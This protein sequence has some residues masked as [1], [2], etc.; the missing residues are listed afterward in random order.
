MLFRKFVFAIFLSSVVYADEFRFDPPK[1]F[2][3]SPKYIAL[4]HPV[5]TDKLAA[6]AFFDQGLT[7][8]Y[9]FNHEAAYWS[10][11]RASEEDPS[12]PMAYWGQAL[13]LGANI[14]I[15]IVPNRAEVAYQTIQKALQLLD[16]AT[17][18]EKDYINALSE[19]YSKD[20]NADKLQLAVNYN[21]AMHKL[22][23]KYPDDPDA[24][25]LYAESV[26]NLSPWN[27]WSGGA[28]REG[29]EDA[30]KALD[31][32]LLSHPM[33]LGANH[34]YIHIIEASPHP[35]RGLMSAERL[36]TM[37][38]SSGHISHMPAHIFLLVGDYEQA[39]LANERAIA[40]DREY[41]RLYG[42]EGTYP[43]HYLSHN[44]HFL[45]QAYSMQGNYG[46]ARQAA[47]ALDNLY[48]S[49]FSKMPELE[50]YASTLMFTNLRFHK[51]KELLQMPPPAKEAIIT[52][53]LWHFGRSAAFASLGNMQESEKEQK[54]FLENRAKV[55]ASA[56][57]GFNQAVK[58]MELAEFFLEAKMAEA[59][60]QNSQAIDWYGKAIGAQDALNYDEPPNWLFSVRDSL[61][62]ILLKEKRY[63][64][65]EKVFR[66]DLKHHPRN[67]RSLFGL[68]TSLKEQ[69]KMT[70]YYF[71]EDLFQNAWR[72]S[73]TELTIYNL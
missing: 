52:N 69:N 39:A 18:N 51:W 27:Q 34:Y 48:L 13:V 26:L 19:R 14:N 50:Q 47:N 37:L 73:D 72:F 9:A 4:H 40:A 62:A 59:K 71:V 54:L 35:E 46:S 1:N 3:L 49:H 57:Y 29:T 41:I 67:G 61:G 58:V 2:T 16:K 63:E 45:S 64:E 44:Y 28:P 30:I 42:L 68:K 17:E 23:D 12:M 6:Q 55:S 15:D 38:P 56:K 20:Q 31:R 53:A 25:V 60:G 24:T 11:I 22:M 33:H 32:V 21:Q 66:E 36:K 8:L 5:E 10:F 43:V 7:F 65:A 70:N